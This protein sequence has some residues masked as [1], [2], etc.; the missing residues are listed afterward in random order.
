ML[1]D[2]LKENSKGLI[3]T[4]SSTHRGKG[5]YGKGSGSIRS[6]DF[7]AHYSVNEWSYRGGDSDAH[8]ADYANMSISEE[9]QLIYELK[10][11]VEIAGS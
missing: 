6:S 10:E 1:L 7:Q 8:E 11:I 3:K 5:K 9:Q 2:K 4:V